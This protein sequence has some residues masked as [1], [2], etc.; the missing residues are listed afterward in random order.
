MRLLYH[1]QRLTQ[2]QQRRKEELAMTTGFLKIAWV[3]VRESGE[4]QG[5]LEKKV[6]RHNERRIE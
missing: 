3:F 5:K 6:G 2:Q 4:K 1:I